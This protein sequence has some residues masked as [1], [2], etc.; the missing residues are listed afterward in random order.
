MF[1]IFLKSISPKVNEIAQLR[2]ELAYYH[3]AIKYVNH[4]VMNTPC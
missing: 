3:V 4:D 2:F 1:L